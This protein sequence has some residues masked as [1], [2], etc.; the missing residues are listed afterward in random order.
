MAEILGVGLTH[1][2]SLI[3]PDELKNYS[4]TRALSNNDR[5][6]AEQKNPESWPNAMRAEWGDDQGY[7]SAKIHRSKLVDGFRRL[8]TEIDAFKPDVVLVWGDDQYENF[9]E[10][11]IPAFCIMAYEEFECQPMA[12]RDGGQR[13]NVWDEPANKIFR[14]KGHESSRYLA[15]ALLEDGFDI[16]YSYKPLHQEGQGH[17]F[18]N[19]SLIHI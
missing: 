18:V 13:P 19:L 7:T 11:I 15:G 2:P 16:A 9:K 8:R 17:A 12:G 14:Y 5:I 6:P 10:D 4:L 3:V 1:S